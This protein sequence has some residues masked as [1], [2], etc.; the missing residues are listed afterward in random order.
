M[1]MRVCVPVCVLRQIAVARLKLEWYGNS[2]S[3]TQHYLRQS[4]WCVLPFTDP[5]WSGRLCIASSYSCESNAH[6]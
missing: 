1:C 5:N 3:E 4:V 6:E 2:V